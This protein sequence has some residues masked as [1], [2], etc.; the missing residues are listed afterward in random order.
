MW[1]WGS[2]SYSYLSRQVSHSGYLPFGCTTA[3]K[4][5]MPCD[6]GRIVSSMVVPGDL[7]G[8]WLVQ[9]CL[10]QASLQGT[11]AP[12]PHQQH[13]SIS[14]TA[15]AVATSTTDSRL[16]YVRSVPWMHPADL[17]VFFKGEV[18][19][20]RPQ[21]FKQAPPAPASS[22]DI[23]GADWSRSALAFCTSHTMML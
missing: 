8:S 3:R 7:R 5:P 14:N 21:G 13:I 15:D 9:F 22:E 12:S 2:V 16:S 6:A 4:L 17:H 20:C 19:C 1:S 10:C 18:S 11:A 23:S